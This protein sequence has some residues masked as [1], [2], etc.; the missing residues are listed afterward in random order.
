MDKGVASVVR[1]PGR[2]LPHLRPELLRL[3][4]ELLRLHAARE[5]AAPE[6]AVEVTLARRFGSAGSGN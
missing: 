3:S 1:Q 5:G 6:P 4:R 2:Q